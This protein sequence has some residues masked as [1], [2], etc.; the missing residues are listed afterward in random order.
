MTRILIFV[1]LFFHNYIYI[2]TNGRIGKNLNGRPC[3]ILESI[4][5]KTQLLR[6][7]VLV[8]LREGDEICL[9]ASRGGSERNPGWYYNL[10]K[11][12][13]STI[14]IGTER[15]EVTSREI[16][17]EERHEWWVKMDYLNNGGYGRYQER[18]KRI[19]PV[20]ILSIT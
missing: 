19:I 17:G 10:K 13:N 16:F 1:F 5:A 3:L 11:N 2:F 7:N 12:T 20:I 15:F 18:T 14:S 6:K 8:F 4:G 9:I